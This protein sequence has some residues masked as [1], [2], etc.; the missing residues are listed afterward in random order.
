MTIVIVFNQE[1][2]R[3]SK[4]KENL[5]ADDSVVTAKAIAKNLQSLGHQISL[6]ELTK[7]SIPELFRMSPDLFFNQAWGIGNDEN[8]EDQVTEL[9]EK[10]GIIYTGADSK[11]IRLTGRKS[12]VKKLLQTKKIVTPAFQLVSSKNF[13]LNRKLHFPL[14]IKP[15]S[16]DCSL[17]INQKSVFRSA[18][19]IDDQVEKLFDHFK[20]PVLIEE[21]ISGH[22]LSVTVLGNGQKAEALP[23]S[24]I[25]FG[26]SFA[27]KYKIVDFAAKWEKGTSAYKQTKGVCPA[28]ITDRKTKQIQTIARQVFLVTGCRDYARVDFRLSDKNVPYVLEVNTNPAIGPEDGAVRS[29]KAAGYSYPEFL[30]KIVREACLRG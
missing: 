3:D 2:T 19:R 18:Q 11:N 15:D 8:S 5:V 9:L 28:R 1:S 20:E 29:A 7:K 30:D 21:Y 23:I 16:Q 24:E 4:D 12:E 25:V 14:I 17:G 27:N 10:T 26:H 6:F 22:E 13:S